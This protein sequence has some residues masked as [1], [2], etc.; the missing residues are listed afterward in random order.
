MFIGHNSSMNQ[1]IAI[2]CKDDNSHGE[3]K[4][5]CISLRE[6]TTNGNQEINRKFQ[7][8]GGIVIMKPRG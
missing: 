2:Q 4:V 5:W 1:G 7:N 6:N 8:E 3:F